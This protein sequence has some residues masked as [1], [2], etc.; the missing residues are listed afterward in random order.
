MMDIFIARIYY[1]N[2]PTRT[3]VPHQHYLSVYTERTIKFYTVSSV[4]GKETRLSRDRDSATNIS[5]Y[6]IINSNDIS[7]CGFRTPSFID[8]S[9]CF[10]LQSNSTIDISLLSNRSIDPSIKNRIDKRIQQLIE[11][12]KH[13]IIPISAQSFLSTNPRAFRRS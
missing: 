5:R 12:N 4:A 6:E 8:C 10:E 7:K 2:D 3:L 1:P 11:S 13:E 9:E